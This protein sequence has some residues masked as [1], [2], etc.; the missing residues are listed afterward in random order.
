MNRSITKIFVLALALIS[1][2]MLYAQS[3]MIGETSYET[4][5]AAITAASDGAVIEIRGLHTE[6]VNVGKNLTLRGEDPTTDI[7][8][9]AAIQAE[10]QTAVIAAVR[11]GDFD[12][13]LT[14]TIE[15]LGI[16][17]GNSSDNG[18]GINADKITGLITLKNLIIEQNA[19]SRNGGGVSV[20]G[21]KA[22]ITGCV[23][24]NNKSS[25][26]G[27]GLILASNNGVTIDT[28]V[29]IAGSLIDGNEGR[30]G[31]GIYINGN[32]DFGD[33]NK[34]DVSIENSTISN[35]A[36]LSPAAG[37][38]GGGIWSRCALWKGDNTT[39]N[40]TLRMV[41]ATMYNNTHESTLKNGIQFNSTP[42]SALTNFSI[43]NSIVVSQDD[44][45]EKALNF[46]NTNTTEAINNILGGLN[47]LPDFMADSTENANRNNSNG[48]TATFAGIATTLSDEGGDVNVF[49]ITEEATAFN[50][51][52]VATGITL[53][54][55]DA[56]GETRDMMPDAGAFELLLTPAVVMEIEDQ[57]L[58]SGFTPVVIDLSTVFEDKNGD[59]LTFSAEVADDGIVSISFD[60]ANMT[61]MEVG[62]GT[63]TVTITADD[64][65][66]RTVG[67]S[68]TVLISENAVPAIDAPLEDLEFEEGFAST[69]IDLTGRFTDGDGDPITLSVE[70]SDETIVTAALSG[71]VLTITE[72]G[73]GV[74][75][76]TV[77]ADDGNGGVATE[78]FDVEVKMALGQEPRVELS[79][80]PNP[81]SSWLKVKGLKSINTEDIQILDVGGK[82]YSPRLISNEG[83]ISL[84]IS[85][86][87]AGYYLL[88]ID[89]IG[90][91]QL[92]KRFLKADQ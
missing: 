7:I 86:L 63:T 66:G 16:R 59:A 72:V 77:R 37:N 36:S 20:V 64:G 14:I 10:A 11:P 21:S 35:N 44:V 85:Q 73:A 34:I 19:S 48:R 75:T 6:S 18:G 42:A 83:Q 22:L 57:I 3:V 88:V 51:C 89:Q 43:Y 78:R 90:Q 23:I 53:P 8:Q 13:D 9:A 84:D 80:Y 71:D 81:A 5:T 4:I 50:Y 82:R 52:T 46:A 24:T 74:A 76:V 30:N 79:I 55:T 45:A 69:T 29:D 65:T 62:N 87:E 56:R 31:G 2:Q 12:G 47:G 60:A 32:K 26:D 58:Q 28:D 91:D 61:I 70:V 68:F 54:T 67:D 41:H 39:G 25:L 92:V 49:A 40:V 27:G 38:G 17:N 33:N 1:S 15:N